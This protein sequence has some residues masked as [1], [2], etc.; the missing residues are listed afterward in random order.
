[1]SEM[2]SDTWWMKLSEGTLDAEEQAAWEAH[3]ATCPQCAR[4][5]AAWQRLEMALRYAPAVPPLPED[6]ALRTAALI[7]ARRRYPR[8]VQP[9]AFLGFAM[10]GTL[11]WGMVLLPTFLRLTYWV[12]LTRVFGVELARVL[13]VLGRF[14]QT[15]GPLLLIGAAG[16]ML[17]A[18]WMWVLPFL[19]ACVSATLVYARRSGG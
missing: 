18:L 4:E 19:A 16:L 3:R 8:W 13:V 11:V 7:T 10:L 17:F 2:H 12:R 14:W 15:H 5:W 1:M 9:L 6:F